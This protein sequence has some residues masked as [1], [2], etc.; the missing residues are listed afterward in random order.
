MLDTATTARTRPRPSSRIFFAR[1][2]LLNEQLILVG[3]LRYG[4]PERLQLQGDE[5]TEP[6]HASITFD[7]PRAM[8]PRYP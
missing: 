6:L 4:S 2:T 5:V 1:L 3:Y 7:D 8:A